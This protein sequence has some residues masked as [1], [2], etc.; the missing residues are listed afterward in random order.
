MRQVA[1]DARD[2]RR[3]EA[4]RGG[5]APPAVAPLLALQRTAGNQAVVR[6]LTRAARPALARM[7]GDGSTPT[8]TRPKRQNKREARKERKEQEKASKQE[9]ADTPGETTAELTDEELAEE[10]ARRE[11]FEPEDEL[12]AVRMLIEGNDGKLGASRGS[13][14]FGTIYAVPGRPDLVVKLATGSEG[15]PNEQLKTEASSLTMLQ[16]AGLPTAFLG[17][18]AWRGPDDRI[19]RGLL[20]RFITGSFS[21]ETLQMGKFS[22]HEPT[23][24]ELRAINRRTV[25]DLRDIKAKCLDGDI[26]IEDLQF[27]ISEDDG[28]VVLID[29]AR[30]RKYVAKNK[31]ERRDIKEA[32]RA[33]EKRIDGIIRKVETIAKQNERT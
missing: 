25:S 31:V 11:D 22:D 32:M 21:K 5:A 14:G 7:N 12:E 4:D 2:V 30:A 8:A 33:F 9:V 28:S 19:W 1:D 18:I 26:D 13:G 20:M 10:F 15:A 3:E 24:K 27:M 6:L 29:P 16:D 17:P 23:E